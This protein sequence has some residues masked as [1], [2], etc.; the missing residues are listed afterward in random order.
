[1]KFGLGSFILSTL[2]MIEESRHPQRVELGRSGA[3]GG[4]VVEVGDSSTISI[5]KP[6]S[7]VS[8]AFQSSSITASSCWA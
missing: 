1:M 7:V 5:S 2:G 8:T 4:G 6:K 3:V